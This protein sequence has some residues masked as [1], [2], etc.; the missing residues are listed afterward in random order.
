MEENIFKEKPKEMINSNFR[1]SYSSSVESMADDL[2]DD[3]IKKEKPKKKVQEGFD[4]KAG[5]KV[6]HKVFGIGT[7][8]SITEKDGG[9]ELVIAFEKKGIKK[10][11]KNLAP[12][13]KI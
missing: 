2:R 13:E 5:E 8:V 10:L 7:V 6:K 9:D 4:I 3:F 12:L 1:E 11:N